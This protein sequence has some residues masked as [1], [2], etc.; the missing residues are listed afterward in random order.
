ML[1]NSLV[2]LYLT[3]SSVFAQP[4]QDF[5]LKMNLEA[6]KKRLVAYGPNVGFSLRELDGT[7]LFEYQ[8]NL[9]FPPASVAKLISTACS[10]EELGPDFQLTTEFS[11]S[12]QIQN[13]V[14]NGDLVVVAGGDFSFVVE[15]L[16]MLIEKIRFVHQIKEITGKI[17]IDTSYLTSPTLSGFNG[18]EGDNGRSFSAKLS[19]LPINHNS[20]EIWIVP[21]SDKTARVEIQPYGAVDLKIINQ[22]KVIPGRWGGSR[23]NLDYRPS[24][25][26]LILT[27]HI[28]EGDEPKVYYRA[29]DDPYDSFIRLF[30]VNFA[31]LG[32]KWAPRYVIAAK[33]AGSRPLLTHRSRAVSRLLIDINK[34]STNL[35]AEMVLMAAAAHKFGKPTSEEKSR[36]LLQDCIRNF[37]IGAEDILLENASGLSRLSKVKPGALSRFLSKM[38]MK[39]YFPELLVTL[40]VLGRDGTTRSRLKDLE[41]R[42]RLKTGS[43]SDVRALAGYVSPAPGRAWSMVL[44]FNCKSCDLQKWHDVEDGILRLLIEGKS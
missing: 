7:E 32:G 20:F 27:G 42:A 17:I 6:V 2:A 10:L 38:S 15:D 21:L 29:L 33:P 19:A 30:S 31:A 4:A 24:E 39:V 44:F 1:W 43:L 11:Y 18:F 13:G 3:S 16:K 23:T 40:S 36:A 26:K 22:L 8:S 9:A 12:G 14:L 25:K 34:L 35:G 5:K 28:G 41:A 37:G